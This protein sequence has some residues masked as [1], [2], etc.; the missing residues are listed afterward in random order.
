MSGYDTGHSTKASQGGASLSK[1]LGRAAVGSVDV[2]L[3]E[4]PDPQFTV[5]AQ[6]AETIIRWAVA[7]G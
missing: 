6:Q 2:I 7:H 3:D 5:V 1:Q 4:A